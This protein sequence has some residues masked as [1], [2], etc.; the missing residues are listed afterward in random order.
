VKGAAT[1][2]TTSVRPKAIVYTNIESASIS[3][4]SRL[5]KKTYIYH[6]FQT[7]QYLC[8][9]RPNKREVVQNPGFPDQDVQELLM[10]CDK[11]N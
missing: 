2:G 5:K 4:V 1:S 8:N 6:G 3:Q 7:S 11:L 9:R 10:D